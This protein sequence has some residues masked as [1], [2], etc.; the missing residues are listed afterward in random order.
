M[1]FVEK[2]NFSLIPKDITK[3]YSVHE[4]KTYAQ[5][6]AKE[7]YFLTT[8]LGQMMAIFSILEEGGWATFKIHSGQTE[9]SRCIAKIIR[10]FFEDCEIYPVSK[11]FTCHMLVAGKGF[12]RSVVDGMA[13]VSLLETCS[14]INT[15]SLTHTCSLIKKACIISESQFELFERKV[16]LT[17]QKM[18][19]DWFDHNVAMSKASIQA[20]LEG[21][22]DPY[23]GYLLPEVGKLLN[24]LVYRHVSH[25]DITF[26]RRTLHTIMETPFGAQLQPLFM[27]VG[28]P[29]TSLIMP[30]SSH[31]AS[32][33][34]KPVNKIQ[35]S[36]FSREQNTQNGV[37]IQT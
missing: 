17:S 19:M 33:Y 27:F 23:A 3:D 10:P 30:V 37:F 31:G 20:T 34:T 8:A 11:A 29:P 25:E 16:E 5:C 26:N 21:E 14:S 6:K 22:V 13:L 24:K 12:K 35:Y 28:P 7:I 36:S 4:I 1:N 15:I 9:E 32:E 18:F 2:K